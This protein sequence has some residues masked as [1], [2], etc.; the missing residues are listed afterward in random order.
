MLTGLLLVVGTIVMVIGWLAVYPASP[1]DSTAKQAAD[2]MADSDDYGST[3]PGP[4]HG[5]CRLIIRN[6]CFVLD[7]AFTYFN[8]CRAK[9]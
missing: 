9:S 4:R 7:Y 6:P 8:G 2:L 5:K 3:T 1:T